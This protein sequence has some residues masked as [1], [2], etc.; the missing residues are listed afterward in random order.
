M[1]CRFIPLKSSGAPDFQDFTGGSWKGNQ[2]MLTRNRHVVEGQLTTESKSSKK[3]TKSEGKKFTGT[4]RAVYPRRAPETSDQ[5]STL[6]QKKNF[7]PKN[8]LR[9]NIEIFTE[10]SCDS[11]PRRAP[12]RSEHIC[13]FILLKKIFKKTTKYEDQQEHV[14]NS[15]ILPAVLMSL[16][17]IVTMVSNALVILCFLVDQSLRIQSNYFLLNLSICD[18]FIGTV[19]LPLYMVNYVINGKWIFGRTACKLWLAMDYV[20][21]QSSLYSIVLVSYDRFLSV[22][23]AAFYRAE[24]N[25]TKPAII[26]MVA[27]WSLAFILYVPTITCWEYVAGYTNVPDGECNPEFFYIRYYRL[28]SAAVDVF[29][30]FAA[31]VYFDLSIY[32]NI[33][34]RSRNKAGN[35]T[36]DELHAFQK[37]A[38]RY[39]HILVL[40]SGF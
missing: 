5:D 12:G 28:G 23:R 18:F 39:C 25:R 2:R 9:M 21:S 8:R 7:V 31:I 17:I 10:V 24:Q 13:D 26:K 11:Y 20:F 36:N 1:N 19:S 30:P 32:C 29:I 4:S 40:E 27:V 6:A 3:V 33:R 34:A 16:C 35:M 14:K 38:V 15:F 37:R 22:T